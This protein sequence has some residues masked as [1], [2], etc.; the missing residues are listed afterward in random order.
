MLVGKKCILRALEPKDADELI[1]YVNDWEVRQYLQVFIPLTKTDEINF[2]ENVRTQ[3]IALKEFVFGIEVIPEKKLVGTTGLHKVDWKN[4]N[5]EFG[6]AIW[7]KNYWG[8]GIG[9]EATQLLLKY[10]F[11]ELGFHRIYLRVFGFNLRAIKCYE[12][13]G[14]KQEGIL[15]ETLWRDG[16]WH[17]TIIMGI[18]EHEYRE[19]YMKK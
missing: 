7:N 10:A 16:K 6:I 9:T 19:L 15:R 8:K 3:M 14:F 5:A 1:K 12:K 2:I 18:L 17:N 13:V 11:E 4:K